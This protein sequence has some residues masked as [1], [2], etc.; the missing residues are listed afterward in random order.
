MLFQFPLMTHSDLGW[1]LSALRPLGALKHEIDP[2]RPGVGLPKGKFCYF[3]FV[4]VVNLDPSQRS[5]Q[6]LTSF[7]FLV[8]GSYLE[9]P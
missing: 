4:L 6:N 2:L 3:Y 1:A 5:E 8:E 9:P 7:Q